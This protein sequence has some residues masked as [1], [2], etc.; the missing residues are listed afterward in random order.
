MAPA[1][2]SYKPEPFSCTQEA[3]LIPGYYLVTKEGPIDMSLDRVARRVLPIALV[4]SLSIILFPGCKGKTIPGESSGNSLAENSVEGKQTALLADGRGIPDG[5]AARVGPMEIPIE[6]FRLEAKDKKYDLSRNR[7]A[8][9]AALRALD[10]LILDRLFYLE[11]NSRGAT[12]DSRLMREVDI[13]IEV[14]LASMFVSE[15][16]K[17]RISVHDQDLKGQ[18]PEKWDAIDMDM[19]V[20]EDKESA[21]ASRDRVLNGRITFEEE[22]KKS[23]GPAALKGGKVG[24]VLRNTA[25]FPDYS[26]IQ[27]IFALRQ[28]EITEPFE[29]PLGWTIVRCNKRRDLSPGEIEAI[30][31]PLREAKY[32]AKLEEMINKIAAKTSWKRHKGNLSSNKPD[33]V[34]LENEG[35]KYT[36]SDFDTF[37]RIHYQSEHMG[38]TVESADEMFDNF[39]RHLSWALEAR[40]EKFDRRPNMEEKFLTYRASKVS[41]E[42]EK[43]I[44]NSVIPTP[45]RLKAYYKK[46]REKYRE[47]DKLWAIILFTADEKKAKSFWERAV[48]GEDFRKLILESGE[49][50]EGEKGVAEMGPLTPRMFPPDMNAVLFSLREDD[51]SVVIPMMGRFA[52]VKCSRFERGRVIPLEKSRDRVLVDYQAEHYLPLLEKKVADLKIRFPVKINENAVS[53]VAR[54]IE[55]EAQ[56]RGNRPAYH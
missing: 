31:K 54:S 33:S 37:V 35:K 4:F 18:I 36:K 11:S 3:E 27:K 15:E 17:K 25:F 51:I 42:A 38:A 41:V 56:K 39:V 26:H 32:S 34:V 21:Y 14:W 6:V 23:Q 12:Q 1:R 28:G 47:E 5:V 40:K 19:L 8:E 9:M 24:W 44:R 52:V 7:T 16:L 50:A 46:H 49:N 13:G 43:A 22:A 30:L 45:E 10:K 2:D 55:E 29:G 48:K 20:T 53:L